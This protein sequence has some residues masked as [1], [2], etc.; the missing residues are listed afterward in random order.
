MQAKSRA[1][2]G[3]TSSVLLPDVY[4]TFIG[5]RGGFVCITDYNGT[6]ASKLADISQYTDST[7]DIASSYGDLISWHGDKLALIG[8]DDPVITVPFLRR[9]LTNAAA[10][11]ACI[12]CKSFVRIT[13]PPVFQERS[14]NHCTGKAFRF[15]KAGN[16]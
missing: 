5:H 10:I 7:V 3:I 4:R 16:L 8:L 6:Q 2:R 11:T 1:R 15:D 9:K 12:A 13:H 14:V